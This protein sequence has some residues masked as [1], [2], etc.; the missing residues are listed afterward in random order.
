MVW[1]VQQPSVDVLCCVAIHP[2]T[3]LSFECELLLFV[4]SV[5]F[6]LVHNISIVC[7]CVFS[8]LCMH[9]IVFVSVVTLKVLII[10][11]MAEQQY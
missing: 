10:V 11:K 4:G 5:C 8:V 2:I 1:Q 6:M 7:V 3:V 9:C